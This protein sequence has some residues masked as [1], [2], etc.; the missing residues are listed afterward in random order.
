VIYN[1]VGLS[2][3]MQGKLTP[4]VAAVLMPISTVSIVGMSFLLSRYFAKRN[5]L[6]L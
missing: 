3:A 2:Y 6:S 4:V 1:V 5:N